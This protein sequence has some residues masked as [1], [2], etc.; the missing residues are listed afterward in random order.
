MADAACLAQ[1]PTRRSGRIPSPFW[2]CLLMGASMLAG[3][4]SGAAQIVAV[5]QDGHTVYV[6]DFAQPPAPQAAEAAPAQ[7]PELV[8]WSVTERRWKPVPRPSRRAMQAARSAATE[9]AEYVAAQPKT[10]APPAL[11]AN[12]NYARL[13]RGRRVTSQAID[14]AIEQAASRHNVDPNLV[15]AI[16]K[17]ESNFNPAA[18]SRAGA[19]GLMQLMPHTA[20]GLR[21]ANPFDP[22][23]NVDAGVRHLKKLLNSYG[24][25]LRLTLAAYNAGEGAVN[26]SNGVPNYRETRSYVRRITE[27][28]GSGRVDM[29]G[30]TRVRL[31]RDSEGVLN[32]TNVE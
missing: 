28:Y 14:A 17:V 12:P 31:F 27:L 9:V 13:A 30:R 2:G 26:R 15:R 20:R 21:L 8:Y 6:N 29:P 5:E 25:D 1:P 18:V 7:R 23:Q 24:G 11:V 32:M 19:I 4:A 10:Q 22:E 16:I 3:S